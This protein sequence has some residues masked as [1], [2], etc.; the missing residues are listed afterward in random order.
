MQIAENSLNTINNKELE[1][2]ADYFASTLLAP[3]PILKAL[4]IN[5]SIELQH[6][7]GLSVEA[8]INKYKS[9]LKWK[10]QHYKNYFDTDILNIFTTFI[11]NSGETPINYR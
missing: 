11:K 9:Y 1:T 4:N 7:F 8:S 3:L 10:N 6:I 2:E 5:S